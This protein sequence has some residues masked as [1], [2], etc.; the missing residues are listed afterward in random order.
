MLK[1]KR[2]CK[3]RFIY[4]TKIFF[5]IENRTKTFSEK[6]NREFLASRPGLQE[7]LKKKFF[8]WKENK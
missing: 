8:T 5:N 6:E 7:M 1:E 3:T 2:N 4:L